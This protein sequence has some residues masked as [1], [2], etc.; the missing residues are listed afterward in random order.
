MNAH[1]TLIL[2]LLSISQLICKTFSTKI[3]YEVSSYS[4]IENDD[5]NFDIDEEETQYMARFPT[6]VKNYLHKI[7]VF[8][9]SI[10]Y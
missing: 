10:S 2:L 3:Q 5:G 9:K 6:P 8:I 1:C 7:K 4:D